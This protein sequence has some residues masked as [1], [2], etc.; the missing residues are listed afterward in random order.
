MLD[1]SKKNVFLPAQLVDME[2]ATKGK[3]KSITVC[4]PRIEVEI[5]ELLS[6]YTESDGVDCSG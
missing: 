3:S 2:T 1:H 6:E 5:Q 4:H